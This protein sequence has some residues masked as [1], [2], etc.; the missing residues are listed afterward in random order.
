LPGLA[1]GW[2]MWA[3]DGSEMTAGLSDS[4][5]LRMARTGIGSLS[6]EDALELFDRALDTERTT[7]LPIRMDRGV[8]RDRAAEDEPP[9]LLR[10]LAGA[11]A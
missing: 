4:D 9:P 11:P 1:L 7:V 2:G 3:D 8:L 5:R 10:K 6:T